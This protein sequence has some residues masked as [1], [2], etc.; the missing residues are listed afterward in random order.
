MSDIRARLTEALRQ[1]QFW[2][3]NHASIG[4]E[5]HCRCG[6]RPLNWVYWTSHL[7]DMLLSLP[8][9]AIV[10]LP[11]VTIQ[12]D[13]YSSWLFTDAG[14]EVESVTWPAA[15]DEI[16]VSGIGSY[17]VSEARIFAAALLA[18]ANAAEQAG[19]RS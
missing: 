2:E 14:G 18:A 11:P 7:A 13:T 5:A 1:H 17:T 4:H 19:V 9:I 12:R 10:D 3:A 8:G 16:A 6:E 15:D